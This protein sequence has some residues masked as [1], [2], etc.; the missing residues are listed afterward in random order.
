MNQAFGYLPLLFCSV[1]SCPAIDKYNLLIFNFIAAW[2]RMMCFVIEYISHLL[3]GSY[4]IDIS[5][6][7]IERRHQN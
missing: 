6:L 1:P 4:A 5:V 7:L 2:A 3:C